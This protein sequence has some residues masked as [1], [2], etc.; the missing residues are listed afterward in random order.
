[1]DSNAYKIRDEARAQVSKA[2]GTIKLPRDENG[3]YTHDDATL[4]L[5]RIERE[6][7]RQLNEHTSSGMKQLTSKTANELTKLKALVSITWSGMLKASKAK[8]AKKYAED[9][10]KAPLIAARDD[11]KDEADRQNVACLATIGNK[12]GIIEGVRNR[13]G[14]AI[15][16]IVLKT[17]DATDDKNVDDI[18]IHSEL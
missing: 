14:G 18:D 2:I 11:A 13:V 1:M 5:Q 15:T 6:L 10:D 16:D 4:F 17:A 12:E 8:A 7:E 9:E 3:S